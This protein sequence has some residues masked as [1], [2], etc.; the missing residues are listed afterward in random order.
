MTFT[1][2]T[3]HYV[4]NKAGWKLEL[5]Q[6][7]P[8]KKVNVRRNPI[9]IIP[10]YGMNSFIFGFHP[11]GLSM[12]DYLTEHGFEVWSLNLRGQ[13]GS[14]ADGGH[15]RFSLREL[16]V[17]DLGA[18]LHHIARHSVSRSGKVDLIGCSLGGTLAFIHAALVRHNKIGA[19]VAMG[20]PL[21]WEAVHPLLKLLFFSPFLIG[22]IPVARARLI[23]RMLAPL[24]LDSPLLKL[25][26][27]REI[28]DLKNRDVL[29][30]TVEDPNRFLNREIGHWI[31]NKDLI[32]DRKNITHEFRKSK[33]PLL[34]VLA[35]SDGIV[36][37]MTA[38]SA[39]ETSGAKVK[40]T[41]VV[42]TD[43]LR[44]AHADLF[45]SNHSHEMVF[46]P[47]AE[48]LLKVSRA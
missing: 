10:G 11:R 43:R 2:H 23:L 27:H 14:R 26:L 12:E 8:P 39:E 45:I 37:P 21:R 4:D 31:K 6:C 33:N 5:K 29:L 28:V 34:C 20:A 13:G 1:E 19:I 17:D 38:L 44:F 7:R 22:L 40:E 24:F 16:A 41:L 18:A 32:I 15:R 42:G 46:K 35:N 36:P 3:Y 25:Y 47:T 30:E 48:W 9:A